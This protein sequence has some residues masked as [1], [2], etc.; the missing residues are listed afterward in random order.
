VTKLLN[1][2]NESALKSL[3]RLC[4]GDLDIIIPDTSV[5]NIQL[6]I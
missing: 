3:K 4:V 5:G 2:I 6:K 1:Y